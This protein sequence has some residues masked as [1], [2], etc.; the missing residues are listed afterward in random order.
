[1]QQFYL[2]PVDW[3]PLT[4]DAYLDAAGNPVN[5]LHTMLGMMERRDYKEIA[6]D[7][8]TLD[9]MARMWS[10]AG[11]AA[12]GHKF[13]DQILREAERCRHWSKVLKD[14]MHERGESGFVFFNSP[15]DWPDKKT[16]VSAI[17]A[18][19]HAEIRTIQ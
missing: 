3:A 1:M 5:F 8:K 9:W 2:E 12:V 7:H 6:F 18:L 15:S 19:Q 16:V 11:M 17:R 14:G 4:E 13:R 10:L